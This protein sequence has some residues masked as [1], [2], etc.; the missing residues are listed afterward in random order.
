VAAWGGFERA[1]DKRCGGLHW[2]FPNARRQELF[3]FKIAGLRRLANTIGSPSSQRRVCYPFRGKRVR[4]GIILK[5]TANHDVWLASCSVVCR[6][7]LSSRTNSPGLSSR[8]PEGIITACV[9]SLLPVLRFSSFSNVSFK[10]TEA[11]LPFP[12]I[13]RPWGELRTSSPFVASA[14]PRQVP[15]ASTR[16]LWYQ[17]TFRSFTFFPPV[18]R[19]R[20]QLLALSI[21]P[22]SL[23]QD[24]RRPGDDKKEG[25]EDRPTSH[26]LDLLCKVPSRH[27][28]HELDRREPCSCARHR[29]KSR[30][31][32]YRYTR[33]K[34]E[35]KPH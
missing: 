22:G 26:E 5:H 17:R 19:C 6:H 10:H 21:S 30:R 11:A 25:R 1:N 12:S 8:R 23:W 13:L 35:E 7:L 18:P 3:R 34:K 2:D 20:A 16:R 28:A 15:P 9:C 4:G 32:G 24:T 27:L 31:S 29:D 14:S 33:V